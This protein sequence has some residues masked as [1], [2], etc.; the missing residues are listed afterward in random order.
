MKKFYVF[1]F[2]PGSS[3]GQPPTDR[4]ERETW[5]TDY[6][7]VSTDPRAALKPRKF[8]QSAP[9]AS[10]VDASWFTVADGESSKSGD[11]SAASASATAKVNHGS[12]YQ[13]I[14]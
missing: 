1:F 4:L 9:L 7:P 2:Q 12:I 6:L 3:T 5:M 14:N 13:I 8:R 10:G 11:V